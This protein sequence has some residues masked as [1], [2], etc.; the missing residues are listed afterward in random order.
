VESV[1]DNF[2]PG[3]FILCLWLTRTAGFPLYPLNAKLNPSTLVFK[4]TAVSLKISQP[5]FLFALPFCMGCGVQIYDLRHQFPATA[6]RV[7][8]LKLREIHADRFTSLSRPPPIEMSQRRV[9]P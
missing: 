9:R 3:L 6:I 7:I 2:Q 4:K 1:L 8:A 5:T